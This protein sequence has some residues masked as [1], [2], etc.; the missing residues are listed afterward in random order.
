MEIKRIIPKGA[1]QANGFK[2]KKIFVGGI[3]TTVTGGRSAS[4][5]VF[6]V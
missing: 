1:A 5:L 3:S 4:K 6:I 2:T